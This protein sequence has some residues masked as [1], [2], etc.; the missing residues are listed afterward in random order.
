MGKRD[1][2]FVRLRVRRLAGYRPRNCQKVGGVQNF[3]HD[4][5]FR[6]IDSVPTSC[7]S[8]VNFKIKIVWCFHQRLFRW[9]SKRMQPHGSCDIWARPWGWGVGSGVGWTVGWLN[10]AFPGRNTC[11]V[12]Q[13]SQPEKRWQSR[14]LHWARNLDRASLGSF[15]ITSYSSQSR[16]RKV[17]FQFSKI[18]K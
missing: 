2:F 14:L 12:A 11:W 5:E 15:K 3:Q 8:L 4:N 17:Y 9:A 6:T 16:F 1:G 18:T 7:V 13:Q 10:G